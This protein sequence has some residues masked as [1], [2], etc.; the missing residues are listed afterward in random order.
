MV[1]VEAFLKCLILSLLPCIISGCIYLLN[2][3]TPVSVYDRTS[4]AEI[5]ISGTV[6]QTFKEE[7]TK[8]E[9]Y[10]SKIKIKEIYKGKNVLDKIDSL[11][12]SDIFIV[13]N[14]GDKNMCY[15]D[16][17]EGEKYIFF[18]TVY[19]NRLSAKY[20]DFFGAVVEDTWYTEEEV[21]NQLGKIR[22]ITIFLLTP[23]FQWGSYYS[24]FSFISNQCFVDRC[25]S[26]CTFSWPSCC[27]FF[28]DLRILITP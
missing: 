15:S 26:F 25:L 11:D 21:Y 14:F 12:S 1:G 20:D 18:L 22:I 4:L 28:F 23:V 3:W 19:K 13:G 24:I 8:S 7:R 6:L 16:V 27:L 9:T 10:E 5:V 17:S 2:G